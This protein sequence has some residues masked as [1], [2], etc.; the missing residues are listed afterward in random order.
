MKMKKV[1]PFLQQRTLISPVLI[2]EEEKAWHEEE[3]PVSLAWMT[4]WPNRSFQSNEVTPMEN[5]SLW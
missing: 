3:E 5:W 4:A 1:T 2:M